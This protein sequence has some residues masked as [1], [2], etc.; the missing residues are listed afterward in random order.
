MHRESPL[1]RCAPTVQRIVPY[2]LTRFQHAFNVTPLCR[3]PLSVNINKRFQSA[4]LG[5]NL[6]SFGYAYFTLNLNFSKEVFCALPEKCLLLF[7]FVGPGED[8]D[9]RTGHFHAKVT[10]LH[11][12]APLWPDDL[13]SKTIFSNKWY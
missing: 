2:V 7:S 5:S 11:E 10:S 9:F 3:K 8:E 13:A 6:E 1:L 12:L 4:D